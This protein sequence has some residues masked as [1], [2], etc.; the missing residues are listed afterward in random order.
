MLFAAM[1]QEHESNIFIILR[2]IGNGISFMPEG[3]KSGHIGQLLAF[4]SSARLSRN[5]SPVSFRALRGYFC[6]IIST[7]VGLLIL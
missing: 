5:A 6:S 1:R 2:A 7:L 3:C 4:T